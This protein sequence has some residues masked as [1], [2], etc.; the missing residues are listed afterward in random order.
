[1]AAPG[2]LSTWLATVTP[3]TLH[4]RAQELRKAGASDPTRWAVLE[5]LYLTLERDGIIRDAP[6]SEAGEGT[7]PKPKSQK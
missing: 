6:C 4:L 1:M 3:E 2:Y 7:E 5:R